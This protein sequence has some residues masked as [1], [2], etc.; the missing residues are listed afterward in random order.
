[1][2]DGAFY[3]ERE[4]AEREAIEREWQEKKNEK[5]LKKKKRRKAFLSN[6]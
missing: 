4:W 2:A 1:M 5:D 3:L 6:K